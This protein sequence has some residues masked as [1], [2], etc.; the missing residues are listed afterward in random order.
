MCDV[1]AAEVQVQI[2]QQAT[3]LGCVG[4]VRCPTQGHS[5]QQTRNGPA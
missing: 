2:Q 1:V 3:T 5:H 4:G